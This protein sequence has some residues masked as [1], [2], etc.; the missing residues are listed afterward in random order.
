MAHEKK[1][2]GPSRHTTLQRLEQVTAQMPA[3]AA[4]DAAF[5]SF[6]EKVVDDAEALEQ[7]RLKLRQALGLD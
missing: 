1:S 3:D 2:K 5:A 7:A 4:L 6:D